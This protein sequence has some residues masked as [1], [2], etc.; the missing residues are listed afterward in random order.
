MIEEIT[1][2][3]DTKLKPTMTSWKSQLY[4][5]NERDGKERW[6][7]GSLFSYKGLASISSHFL[8]FYGLF[9]PY[10]KPLTMPHSCVCVYV[11]KCAVDMYVAEYKDDAAWDLVAP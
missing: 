8:H 10:L 2:K 5:Y 1:I 7:L 6:E 3:F 4:K 9:N 11:G